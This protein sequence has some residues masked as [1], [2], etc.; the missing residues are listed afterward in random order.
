VRLAA[1][2]HHSLPP[3][4][5]KTIRY[6][7]LMSKPDEALADLS[8]FAGTTVQAAEIRNDARTART[9]SRNRRAPAYEGSLTAEDIS[10]IEK[11]AGEELRRLG[12]TL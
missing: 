9:R 12:Y 8:R 7:H 3:G 4:R 6:E 1:R 11:T 10:E 2:L 5:L